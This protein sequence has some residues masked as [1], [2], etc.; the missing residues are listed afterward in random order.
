MNKTTLSRATLGRLPMYLRYLRAQS[1]AQISASE[2]ARNLK[3][4]EVLVRKD[5]RCVCD[6]GR[7]KIGY[8]RRELMERIEEILGSRGNVPVVVVGAG[9]LGRALMRY[10]GFEDFGLRI[11]AG[12]DSDPGKQ[13]AADGECPVLPMEG[14]R[15]F[16]RANGVRVGVVA[17]PEAAA[18]QVCDSMIDAG[19]TTLWN[20][21][22]RSLA[23]PAGVSVQNE[24]LALSLAHLCLNTSRDQ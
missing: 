22:P 23:T 8:P 15:E 3:L 17:V 16:C 19:L 14:L 9:K 12:F 21:A 5:L 2:M 13:D 1:D 11:L 18:Q 10:R 4:G 7:P 24:N 20:F 6:Q